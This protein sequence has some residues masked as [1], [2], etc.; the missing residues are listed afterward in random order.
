MSINDESQTF[1]SQAEIP[2][3]EGYSLETFAANCCRGDLTQGGKDL[4]QY[5]RGSRFA[6]MHRCV[7][8]P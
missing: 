1:K 7:R 2:R 6:V 4:H 5:G 8:L 3:V